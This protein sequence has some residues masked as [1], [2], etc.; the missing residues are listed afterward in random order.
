L[1]SSFCLVGYHIIIIV[2]DEPYMTSMVPPVPNYVYTLK[3]QFKIEKV[4][5]IRVRLGSSSLFWHYGETNCLVLSGNIG[6]QGETLRT[7]AIYLCR[8]LVCF[9]F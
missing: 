2:D 5:T 4:D 6:Q 3:I 1:A 8:H 7:N 9:W